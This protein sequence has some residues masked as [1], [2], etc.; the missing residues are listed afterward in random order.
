M[1]VGM[2]EDF[3]VVFSALVRAGCRVDLIPTNSVYGVV[4]CRVMISHPALVYPYSRNFHLVFDRVVMLD[5]LV[6]ARAIMC[7]LPWCVE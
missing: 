5:W 3:F 2:D 7:G 4:Y 6:R 1:T